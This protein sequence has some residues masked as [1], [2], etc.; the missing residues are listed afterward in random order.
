MRGAPV[1]GGVFGAGV[2]ARIAVAVPQVPRSAGFNRLATA[3]AV[4]AASSD[5]GYERRAGVPVTRESVLPMLQP[6]ASLRG[7]S[8]IVVAVFLG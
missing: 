2:E 6:L 8:S 5:D 3:N 1:A 4:D 7:H